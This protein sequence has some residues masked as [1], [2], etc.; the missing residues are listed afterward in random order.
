MAKT[1]PKQPPASVRLSPQAEA[2][3]DEML[4]WSEAQ[5]GHGAALRYA[6]LV[7]Q[8][9]R[10]L[11]ADAERPGTKQRPELPQGVYTYHLASS[12][13]HVGVASRVK[14]PRHFLLYRFT[15]DRVEVLRILHDSRDLA[16]HLPHA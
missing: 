6:E 9:V 14:T 5:F 8:A 11:G 7:I 15:A 16:Q 12:R 3:L 1:V 13:E 10:D 4:E 2:D